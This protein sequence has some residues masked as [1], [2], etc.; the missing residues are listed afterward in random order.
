[1]YTRGF[2]T[3]L[4]LI[5]EALALIMFSSL[6]GVSLLSTPWPAMSLDISNPSKN[7]VS[8]SALSDGV[9]F[10]ILSFI[11]LIFLQGWVHRTVIGAFLLALYC[12]LGRI[13]PASEE[14][15]HF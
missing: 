12:S 4:T 11:T 9:P 3:V 8:N 1:M 14:L 5:E 2:S 7:Y 10:V 13:F 6:Y 15:E